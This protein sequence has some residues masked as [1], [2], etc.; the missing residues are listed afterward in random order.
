MQVQAADGGITVTGAWARATAPGQ[1][2]ASVQ[3]SI[4]SKEA[5]K[6][7]AVTSPAAGQ[8]EIH[9]MTHENGGMQM[10]SVE[11]LELPAG[12]TVDL[13]RRGYHM[14]LLGLKQPLKGGES[15]PL[16]LTVE[17]AGK[18]KVALEV[19]ARVLGLGETHDMVDMG[20][21]PRHGH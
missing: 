7:V 1:D 9:H 12:K 19:K 13:G 4:T 20:G 21:M 15:V 2:S 18:R 8:A 3:L 11:F 16:T 10:R 5:A 6:L 14:M 17:L